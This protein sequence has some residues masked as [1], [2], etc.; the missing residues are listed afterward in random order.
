MPLDVERYHDQ[1]LYA[2]ARLGGAGSRHAAGLVARTAG[3]GAVLASLL[4]NL[5]LCAAA[6]RGMHSPRALVAAI[7][8]AIIAVALVAAWPIVVGRLLVPGA[9]A[10]L[11]IAGLYVLDPVND[12]KIAVEL[13]MIGGFACLGARISNPRAASRLLWMVTLLVLAVGLWEMLALPSF[14]HVFDIY[15]YYVDKGA[16][17]LEHA[18][19]TGTK[20]AENGMRPEGEGRQLLS[21]FLGLHRVGSIFLEPV[22]AGNFTVVCVAWVIARQA[23]GRDGWLLI[24]A[25]LTVGVLADAR[26][27]IISSAA[28]AAMLLSGAWRSR[29]IVAGLPFVMVAALLAVG[30]ATAG[31]VDNTIGGRLIGSGRLLAGWSLGEWLGLTAPASVS[32]DTGYSYVLG[33]LGTVASVAIWLAVALRPKPPAAAR[34]FAVISVY[35]TLALSISYSCF[36]IKTAALMW[37]LYGT[38]LASDDAA[39]GMRH[40]GA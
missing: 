4:F 31:G 37:F 10:V 19:D 35:L 2:A 38:L 8:V 14:E 32:M 9:L 34:F 20:L 39:H 17:T 29:L 11:C 15:G 1:S 16:L 13:A 24:L 25:A 5:A 40:S 6:T 27:S 33:N 7:E 30:V 12:P 23:V 28:V 21:G 3:Y 18:N 26:F 22:S 36:S